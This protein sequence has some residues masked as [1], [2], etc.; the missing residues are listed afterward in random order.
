MEKEEKEE[1]KPTK[2][3]R[4]FAKVGHIF[5]RIGHG[6]MIAFL[7]VTAWFKRAITVR[8]IFFCALGFTAAMVL[9]Y[10]AY[11]YLMSSFINLGKILHNHRVYELTNMHEIAGSK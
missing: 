6:L 1:N 4:F 3:T 2:Y 10:F 9:C 8:D 7:F 5:A 11:D